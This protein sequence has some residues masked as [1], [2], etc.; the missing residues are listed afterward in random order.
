MTPQYA[1]S[2]GP[3]NRVWS[4]DILHEAVLRVKSE[5]RLGIPTLCVLGSGFCSSDRLT[6]HQRGSLEVP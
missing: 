1:P 2:P 5:P 6:A 4:E 3:H